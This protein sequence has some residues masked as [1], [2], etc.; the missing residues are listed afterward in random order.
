MGVCDF[1]NHIL[2]SRKHFRC[3][4]HRVTPHPHESARLAEGFTAAGFQTP[5]GRRRAKR[6]LGRAQPDDV[7][8]AVV[9]VAGEWGQVTKFG[10]IVVS[11]A[12]AADA[13]VA[14]RWFRTELWAAKPESTG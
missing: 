2:P 9:P 3:S 11:A 8:V 1:D 14:E 7:V 5:A 6:S 10:S 13:R 4:N 12:V